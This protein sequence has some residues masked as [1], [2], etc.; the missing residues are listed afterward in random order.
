MHAICMLMVCKVNFECRVGRL[1]RLNMVQT[2]L[3]NRI[4]RD[5]VLRIEM[6]IDKKKFF[7]SLYF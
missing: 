7:F 1:I 4:F 2:V 5:E 6:E 3:E